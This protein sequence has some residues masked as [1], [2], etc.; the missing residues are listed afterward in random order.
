[1]NTGRL[2]NAGRAALALLLAVNLSGCVSVGVTR[3]KAASPAATE[4]SLDVVV[5]DT[6]AQAR[7]GVVSASN[8]TLD[9]GR[10][11]KRRETPLQ[12]S[13]GSTWSFGKLQPGE[14]RMH[15]K[16]APPAP[17]ITEEDLRIKAGEA[18]RAQVILK[19]FPTV[20]VVGVT[21]GVVAAAGIAA[22]VLNSAF[23][24][25]LG[26]LQSRKRSNTH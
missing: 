9:L 1:M 10:V 22:A 14:Y 21:L 23:R 8:M 25:D 26:K 3:S 2:R 12:S 6:P 24:I 18:V 16:A 5:Y 4:G 17:A 7:A 11:E 15:L 13:P 20:T 19:K